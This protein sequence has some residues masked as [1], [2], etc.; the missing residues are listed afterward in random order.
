LERGSGVEHHA[1]TIGEARRAQIH[2]D[3]DEDGRLAVDGGVGIKACG[4]NRA[5]FFRRMD[6]EGEEEIVGN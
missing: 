6:F 2:F 4:E 5:D 1:E 3:Q